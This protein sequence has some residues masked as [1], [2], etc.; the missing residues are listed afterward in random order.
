[1]HL[2][3]SQPLACASASAC[4]AG[5]ALPRAMTDAESFSQLVTG[6][7]T[8]H[9]DSP[10]YC[11]LPSFLNSLATLYGCTLYIPAYPNNLRRQ[12][13]LEGEYYFRDGSWTRLYHTNA[14]GGNFPF[15]YF[16]LDQA[17]GPVTSPENGISDA[18]L[19]KLLADLP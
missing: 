15:S 9:L 8:L 6:K 13:L 18:D 16:T 7:G 14:T 12:P 5:T 4:A 17:L 1:M 10:Y 2:H 19:Y 3:P 11:I